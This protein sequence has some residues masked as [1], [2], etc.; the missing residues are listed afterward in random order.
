MKNKIKTIAFDADDTLW[1]NEPYFQDA[2]KE[3]CKLFQ[4]YLP[5]HSVSEELF[6]TEMKNLHL[7]GYGVKGFMLCMI[8]TI[9][10]ISDDAAS[11]RLVNKT[12]ELGHELLQKP[13][14]LLDGVQN[15][16]ESLAG[17][18][19]LVVATKGDLLDQERKLKNSGLVDF[20]HHI[21]IMSDKQTNDYKK[22][23]KHLDCTPDHFLMLGNSVKSD[24]MPV[25][26]LGGYAA[27]IPYHTTWAHEQHETTLQHD[28]FV[29]LKR[30]DHILQHL[31]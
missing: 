11:L 14:Q 6:K 25:L 15:T 12:I 9:G 27:H 13:I 19:K 28:N 21:E 18:Y 26:D 1:V 4:D 16:L 23:L 20:F 31:D 22:L 2:E 10:R 7:Y 17:K 29:E 24:I 5:E 8:E 3:F 30:I